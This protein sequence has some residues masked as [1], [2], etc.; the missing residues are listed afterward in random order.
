MAITRRELFQIW[1]NESEPANRS[2]V[3]V[4]HVISR[5]DDTP[6]SQYYKQVK[7]SV[8]TLCSK[9]ND[10]WTKANR[11]LNVFEQQNGEWL[12]NNINLPQKTEE[13][14]TEPSRSRVGRPV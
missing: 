10:K 2:E 4:R 7:Q 13:P 1:R 3:V 5:V 11:T 14:T 6:D 9:F 8:R 12:N